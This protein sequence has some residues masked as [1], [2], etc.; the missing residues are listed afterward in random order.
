MQPVTVDY[1]NGKKNRTTSVRFDEALLEELDAFAQREKIT[2]AQA[3]R[4]LV[5]DGLHFEAT[6]NVKTR[7][8][9]LETEVQ[10][11][12]ETIPRYGPRSSKKR[13]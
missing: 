9:A 7:L 4:R 3:L 10:T 2:R 5:E 12:K 6:D 11:I 13:A 1:V 8:A